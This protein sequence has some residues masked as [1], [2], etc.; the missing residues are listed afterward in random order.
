MI[1]FD[2]REICFDADFGVSFFC[3]DFDF[4]SQG[5]PT[6]SQKMEHQNLHQNKIRERQKIQNHQSLS[7]LVDFIF[8]TSYVNF[9]L[10][11]SNLFKSLSRSVTK[12]PFIN[13]TISCLLI[14]LTITHPKGEIECGGLAGG[15]GNC[16]PINDGCCIAAHIG[17]APR[18]LRKTTP[19]AENEIF[20]RS[21]PMYSVHTDLQNCENQI[22]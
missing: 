14:L 4:P 7:F 5:K 9:V 1:F 13:S 10:L 11:V 12:G 19:G 2:A 16:P 21:A 22:F 20:E 8:P 18:S 17:V 15:V 6:Y 3:Q